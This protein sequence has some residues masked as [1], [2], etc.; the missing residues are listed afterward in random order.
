M[1]C[2]LKQDLHKQCFRTALNALLTPTFAQLTFIIFSAYYDIHKL[3]DLKSKVVKIVTNDFQAWDKYVPTVLKLIQIWDY[4][5]PTAIG[6][7]Y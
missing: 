1:S 5:I 3:P 7:H 4:S 2:V 6:T